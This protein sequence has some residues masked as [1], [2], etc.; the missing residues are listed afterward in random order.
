MGG[1]LGGVV[2]SWVVGS[3]ESVVEAPSGAGVVGNGVS[4]VRG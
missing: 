3:S 2:G 1:A 4:C